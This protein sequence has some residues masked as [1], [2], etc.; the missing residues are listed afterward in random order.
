MRRTTKMIEAKEGR[1][2]EQGRDKKMNTIRKQ[3][4]DDEED[5]KEGNE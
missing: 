2:E 5:K 3:R 1:G 4:E